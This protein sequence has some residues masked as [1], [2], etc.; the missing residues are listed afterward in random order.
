MIFFLN[1]NEHSRTVDTGIPVSNQLTDSK[2][3]INPSSHQNILLN[4]SSVFR[5]KKIDWGL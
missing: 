2:N 3:A 5:E 4:I 1:V